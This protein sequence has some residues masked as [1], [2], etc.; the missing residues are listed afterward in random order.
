MSLTAIGCESCGGSVAMPAG[1]RQP[2]CLFCGA[3]TLVA[4]DPPENVEAPNTLL[5]FVLSNEDARGVFRD[6]ASKRFWAPAAIRSA[7]V[8]LSDLFLPAWLWSGAVETHWAALVSSSR[9]RSGKRPQS[10]VDT[11]SVA[12]L[13]V[14]ASQTLRHAELA[15]I[16]PFDS[17]SEQ[18]FVATTLDR[19]YELGSLTRRAA[20]TAARDA[21]TSDHESQI[22]QDIGALRLATSSLCS[23]LEGKPL[24][25]PVWI[26]AYRVKEKM[27]RVVLNGQNGEI[28]GTA[29]V[30][31]AKVLL[32][33]ASAFLVI[34]ML[35]AVATVL[36]QS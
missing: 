11:L 31:W 29:P 30:S 35:G 1:K 21:M 2:T 36:S 6:W 15:A 28:T 8:E 7:Q 17:T 34:L 16:C 12:G 14:P 27:Y 18:A 23:D 5:P 13:L 33:I 32:A 19:P 9:T 25:L 20:T 10:G 26:G 22:R 24:L 3:E 4:Q